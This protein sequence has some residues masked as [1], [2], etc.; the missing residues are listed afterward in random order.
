LQ[1]ETLT[2]VQALIRAR[3]ADQ[4]QA[5]R[6]GHGDRQA[7]FDDRQQETIAADRHQ[8]GNGQKNS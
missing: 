4:Q 2:S 3:H 6:D 5:K 8:D 7:R 1:P